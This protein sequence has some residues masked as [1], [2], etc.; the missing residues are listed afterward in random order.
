MITWRMQ[1]AFRLLGRRRR[2]PISSCVHY[3]AFRYGRGEE[4]PYETFT[5]C[6]AEGEG[7]G[8]RA[9]DWLT[10]FVRYYRPRDF[11]EALGVQLGSA[12]ALW[13]Y[14]WGR[15]AA[16]P[17]WKKSVFEI[18]DIITHFCEEGVP[19]WRL[20][21]EFYWLEQAYRSIQARGYLPEE[22]GPIMARRLVAEE[23][24]EAFLILDGNHRLSALSALGVQEV[25]VDYLPRQTVWMERVESWP[26]VRAG[27][28][29]VDDAR[30][31]LRAYFE[32]NRSWRTTTE[33]ARLI[34]APGGSGAGGER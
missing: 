20:E 4:H 31:V 9:R 33:A 10:E 24:R 6:L 25:E 18:P 1:W 28:Y 13:D 23:G 26:Q 17:A 14:P 2:V 30:A 22:G 12:H 16:G 7:G 8:R 32:G 19:W 3:C 5:R 27:R 29:S 15:G 34:G 21:Q 11:G